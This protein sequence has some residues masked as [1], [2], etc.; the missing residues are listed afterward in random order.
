MTFKTKLLA[1]TAAALIATG[2]AVWAD[3][4]AT[5][6]VTGEP[7]A[8]EQSFSYSILDDFPSIDPQMVEDVEGGSVARDLFEG[9][10]TE[11]AA[12]EVLPGVAEQYRPDRG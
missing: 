1:T 5:H 6:P 2:G 9:L 10:T 3:G 4:H 11:S 7:L 12:G 8:S